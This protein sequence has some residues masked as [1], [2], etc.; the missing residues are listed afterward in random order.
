MPAPKGNQY[1]L[2]NEGGRPT[3]YRKAWHPKMASRAAKAGLTNQEIS[4]MLGISR[5]NMNEWTSKHQEFR[6]ALKVGKDEADDRMERSLYDAGIA[7]CATSRIFWL[8]NRRYR[9]WRDRREV[10]LS[11]D[12]SGLADDASI[13]A[14]VAKELGEAMAQQLIDALEGKASDPKLLELVS[15]PV[16]S[17]TDGDSK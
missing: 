4:E 15:E 10:E 13:F 14:A 6:D 8:K 16:P 2:G 5:Q 3:K 12:Y 7:G 17:I 1:A 11:H 9:E